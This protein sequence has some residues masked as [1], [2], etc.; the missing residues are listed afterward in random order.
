FKAR[1]V[2]HFLPAQRVG[3]FVQFYAWT[4]ALAFVGPVLLTPPL[5]GGIGLARTVALQPAAMA[6]ATGA[7]LAFPGFAL[8]LVARGTEAVLRGSALRSGSQPLCATRA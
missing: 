5:R 3:V 2:A 6:A 4:S 8:T 1:V 7:L